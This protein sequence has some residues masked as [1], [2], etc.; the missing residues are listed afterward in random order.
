MQ[1]RR[2][3]SS[4][5]YDKPC[6]KRY[7]EIGRWAKHYGEEDWGDVELLDA[8]EDATIIGLP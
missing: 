8:K 5:T 4:V 7:D 6:N 1:Y 3:R 2:F